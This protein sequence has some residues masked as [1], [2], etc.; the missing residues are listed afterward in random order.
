MS[1]SPAETLGLGLLLGVRHAL[2][3]DHVVAMGT[4]VGREGRASAAFRAGLSWGVG[5]TVSV[6]LFGVAIVLFGLRVSGAIER[7]VE[8][9]VALMMIGLGIVALRR[10]DED[11]LE[12]R[13]SRLERVRPAVVG[14]VHGL[15]GSAGL[16][17]L[18]MTTL[19]TRALALGYLVLFGAGTTLSMGLA[20]AALSI[21]ALFLRRKAASRVFVRV[22]GV[23]GLV[24][25]S[26]LLVALFVQS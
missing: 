25:G 13:A 4:L 21:P 5:H 10:R 8:A 2:D 9:L 17:L 23:L 6:L 14:L 19:P 12:R 1:V 20:T 22:A 7:V 24:W 16:A 3:P 15:A 26:G 18:A 11:D